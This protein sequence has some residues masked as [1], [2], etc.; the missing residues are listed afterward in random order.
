MHEGLGSNP[1]V[2]LIYPFDF[3]LVHTGIY[4][5]VPGLSEYIL[6]YT[7]INEYCTLIE[8]HNGIYQYVPCLSQYILSYFGMF[9]VCLS[10]YK[11]V[12][13]LFWNS[14]VWDIN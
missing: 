6:V 14:Q 11:Y 5:Y 1:N 10:T 9:Q 3:F 12:L 8:V 2:M 13:A 7:S 4:Q